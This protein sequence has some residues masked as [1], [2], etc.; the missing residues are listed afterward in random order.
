MKYLVFVFLLTSCSSY[1]TDGG[2]KVKLKI[3]SNNASEF[4]ILD[5]KA[6]DL[7]CT[8]ISKV[9]AFSDERVSEPTLGLIVGLTNKA[10]E[11]GGTLLLSNLSTNTAENPMKTTGEVYKCPKGVTIE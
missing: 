9:E 7:G 11:V 4:Q 6:K 8:Y 5:K 3:L 10:A 1:L 2:Q